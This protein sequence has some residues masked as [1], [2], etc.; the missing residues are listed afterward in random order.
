MA[1]I[2]EDN[3]RLILKILRM[4]D[5]QLP[6]PEYQ[7]ASAS[8]LDLCANLRE[9]RKIY[10]GEK[11]TFGTGFAIAL[12]AGY[13][14]QIRSRSGLAHEHGVVVLNSPGTID[15]DYRGEICVILMNLGPKSYVVMPG[16]RIAQMVVAPVMRCALKL[17]T[18]LDGTVRAEG[19]LG[20]TGT[21]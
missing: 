11:A 10:S 3:G 16:T 9:N 2:F 20:S 7:S 19:G 6:L 12:P 21:E 8:G 17:V 5:H 13:E 14:A 15:A 4:G 1:R 18:E